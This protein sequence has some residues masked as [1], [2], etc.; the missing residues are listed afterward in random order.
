MLL[1]G[2]RG[3]PGMS[4]GSRLSP[5]HPGV[6]GDVGFHPQQ[7][8]VPV[9]MS[10]L[11]A[12]QAQARQ[13]CRCGQR[14]GPRAEPGD[15]AGAEEERSQQKHPSQPQ[16]AGHGRQEAQQGHDPLLSSSGAG[17][18]RARPCPGGGS[19]SSA[20]PCS[21]DGCCVQYL[22]AGLTRSCIPC[23]SAA[24]SWGGAAL[25]VCASGCSQYTG[26]AAAAIPALLYYL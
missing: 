6:C 3:S 23:G 18:H 24:C 26:Q 25:T 1:L 4:R 10:L 16:P 19:L 8:S 17:L 2:C 5:S 21:G 11:C 7:C 9:V 14:Q 15:A 12:L 13:L 20:F 22:A